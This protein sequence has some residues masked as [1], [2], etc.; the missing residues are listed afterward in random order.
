MKTVTSARNNARAVP[1]KP[2]AAKPASGSFRGF[3]T[4]FTDHFKFR[5]ITRDGCH[6]F[7]NVRFNVPGLAQE[8]RQAVAGF[9]EERV[10]E[11]LSDPDVLA[12]AFPKNPA[13]LAPLQDMIKELSELFGS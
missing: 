4:H 9:F 7:R 1:V 3:S 2:D 6:V 10:L 11:E 13:Y 8:E 12:S 5:L